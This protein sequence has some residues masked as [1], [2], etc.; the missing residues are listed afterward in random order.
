MPKNISDSDPVLE[1]FLKFLASDIAKNPDRLRT[2]D[3][4]FVERLQALVGDL[5]VDLSKPLT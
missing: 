1:E 3:H 2:L 5:E 4:E